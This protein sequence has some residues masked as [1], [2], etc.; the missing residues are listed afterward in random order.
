MQ[1]GRSK[2]DPVGVF[3]QAVRVHPIHVPV[4]VK[5]ETVGDYHQRRAR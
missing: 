1:W 2:M 4:V 5:S 3:C